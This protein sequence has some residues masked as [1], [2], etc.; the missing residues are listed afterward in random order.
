MLRSWLPAYS[1]PPSLLI[2]VL[3]KTVS[4]LPNWGKGRGCSPGTERGGGGEQWKK[5]AMGDRHR[6]IMNKLYFWW[7]ALLCWN[8]GA[9]VKE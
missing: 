5:E 8:D 3:E 6:T 4:Y 2:S 7:K 1:T 9:E